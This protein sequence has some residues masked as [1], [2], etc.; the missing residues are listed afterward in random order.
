MEDREK[1]KRHLLEAPPS[2]VCNH[3]PT[4]YKLDPASRRDSC[5]RH[6]L[7]T[8]GFYY[9][10]SLAVGTSE[11]DIHRERRHSAFVCGKN[12]AR[13]IIQTPRITGFWS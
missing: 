13:Q 6:R 2:R 7:D 1:E 5:Q 12:S 8:R 3:S 9:E 10:K 4:P 11:R